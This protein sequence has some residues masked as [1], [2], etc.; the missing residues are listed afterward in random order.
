MSKYI[1]GIDAGHSGVKTV[2]FNTGG[3]I[4][5]SASRKTEL[6]PRKTKAYEEFDVNDNWE[7]VADTIQE[8]IDLSGVDPSDIVGV[9][10]T[11]Y[12]NGAVLLDKDGK[13]LAPGI[14]PQDTRGDDILAEYRRLGTFDQLNSITKAYIFFAQPGP[15]AR[16]YKVHE[17][18]IY[19]KIDCLLLYKSYLTYKLTGN[20]AG[21]L[22]CYGGSA[23]MDLSKMAFTD[24]MFEKF[25]IPELAD[26]VPKILDDCAGV[27]GYVNEEASRRTG[28]AVGT[29]VCA[30]M[31]DVL[32]CLVGA[33]GFGDGVYTLVA[34]TWSINQTPFDSAL[35][36][37]GKSFF[38]MPYLSKGKY[39]VAR[40]TADS[41]CNYEWFA[42]TL[43][44]AA[45]ILA[46]K[47]PG[48]NR[49]EIMNQMIGSVDPSETRVFYH[50][51]ICQPSIH[52]GAKANFFNIDIATGFDEICYAVAEGVVFNHKHHVDE[53]VEAGVP[54]K[55]IRLTGGVAR[56]EVWCQLFADIFDKPVVTVDCDE[57]GALGIAMTA[58]I[59]AG[60][61][62]DYDDAADHAV[63]IRAEYTPNGEK[64]KA[65][66]KRYQE[67]LDLVEIMTAYWSGK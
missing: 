48:A 56:S 27:V 25:G 31:M 41:A 22:N 36:K 11:T 20:Y 67:W 24:E 66:R 53:M 54:C 42:N 26:K 28:L 62:R 40:N 47:T 9:G 64:H 60:V 23:F 44:G 38:N 10:A 3:S 19:D 46:E 12:G 8:C 57:V 16:W 50:P 52:P 32:A 6:L 4:I 33:A 65:Y 2:L 61:F 29:A 21:D 63:K 59:A 37:E 15:I 34:G 45:R 5:A 30:G 43:G 39:L 17:P 55:T 58:G 13:V 7:H 14:L 35:V 51:F 18:E 1:M 49:F